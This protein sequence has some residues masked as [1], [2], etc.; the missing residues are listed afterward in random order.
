MGWFI[1]SF[2]MPSMTSGSATPSCS[3][4]MASLSIGQSILLLTKPGESL[5]DS[6]VLPILS[7]VPT[8]AA[9]TS[10]EVWAP[11][12]IS[13]S[14][15]IGT[16]F[17]K[18][19]P[20]TLSGL[21]VA[22]AIASM[23]MLEVLLARMASGL[24]MPSSSAKAESFISGIS[25]IASTTRSQPDAAPLSVDVRTRARAESASSRLILSLATSLPRERSMASIPRSM[26]SC[27]M[28]IIVTSYPAHAATCAM[29]LPI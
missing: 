5:H 18:C 11:L 12:M 7:T 10:S 27:S 9:L 15:I 13:T 6:A 3:V 29:P 20:M 21:L 23:L 4:R 26:N 1:P 19:I 22:P 16:G 28:S 14:R 17:M 24:Q 25:G 8:T 2:M